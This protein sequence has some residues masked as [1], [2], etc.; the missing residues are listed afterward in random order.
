[1]CKGGMFAPL[2][3]QF[4]ESAPE[5]K[6]ASHLNQEE[7]SGDNKRNVKETKTLKTMDG[8][9]TIS[10]PPL[11]TVSRNSLKYVGPKDK[12]TFMQDLKGIY[13]ALG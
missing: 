5:G 9:V 8:M 12:K 10:T 4:L 7:R 3:R 6:M 11:R 1:M 13:Q 2:L